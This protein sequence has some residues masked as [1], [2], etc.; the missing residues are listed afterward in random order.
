MNKRILG[1]LAVAAM[2]AGGLA[3]TSGTATAVVK[4]D[5]PRACFEEVR[6]L[7]YQHTVEVRGDVIQRETQTRTR[8]YIAAVEAVLTKWWV[9]SPNRNW[10][11]FN[12]P[13]EFPSDIRGT[14]QGPKTEGGP[15]QNTFGTFN[16]SNGNSGNSSWFHRERGTPVVAARWSGWSEWGLWT[17]LPG[18]AQKNG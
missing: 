18:A 1:G 10:E 5:G 14:W 12:G 16:A 8:T 2:L 9:W 3:L 11:P 4:D 7:K 6:E 13:P 17:K 15:D